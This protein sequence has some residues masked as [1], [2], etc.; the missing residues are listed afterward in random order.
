ME[1]ETDFYVTLSSDS[2]S[3]YT[4]ND[5]NLFK[6]KLSTPYKLTGKWK[7]AMTQI[8]YPFTW[9]NLEEKES[10]LNIIH[11]KIAGTENFAPIFPD[12]DLGN[13][14]K[15]YLLDKFKYEPKDM[16]HFIMTT[17]VFKHGYY[18]NVAALADF[19]VKMFQLKVSN[20][21]NKVL[22]FDYVSNNHGDLVT[23]KGPKAV[24]FENA[25]KWKDAL[26]MESLNQFGNLWFSYLECDATAN[27]DIIDAIYVYSSLVEFNSV[28]DSSVPLLTVVPVEGKHGTKLTYTP[29]RPEYKPVAQ[30]YIS[31]IEINLCRSNG[32]LIDFQSKSAVRVTLHFKRDGIEI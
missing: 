19:I 12:S 30:D 26:K 25:T 27:L 22:R 23:F 18:E 2:K 15:N 32:S 16:S 4:T 14:L 11:E 31:E 1:P 29:Q 13:C 20:T 5:N 7:V 28:G 9:R 8:S 6:I 3:H 17:I 21:V 24:I 10:V